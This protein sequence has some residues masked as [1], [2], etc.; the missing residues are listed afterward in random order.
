[1][2]RNQIRT[3]GHTRGGRASPTYRSWQN[4]IARC[5]QPSNP[6]FAHYRERGIAVCARWQRFENFLADMGERPAGKHLFTVERVDNNAGYEPGNCRWATWRD[7]G[8]NRS[9]NIFFEYEGRRFTMAELARHTGVKK[10]VLRTRLCRSKRAWTVEGA[11]RTPVIPRKMR[12]AG[13]CA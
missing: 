5:A 7:Q 12:R 4:M 8:N 10:D 13:V 2:R 1:M 11:V 6:A 3:H 9:T